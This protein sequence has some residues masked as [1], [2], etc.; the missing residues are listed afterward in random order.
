MGEVLID[1]LLG[2]LVVVWDYGEYSLNTLGVEV[3][4]A[5]P[6]LS[7]VVPPEADHD[8]AAPRHLLYYEAGDLI[9]LLACQA[10]RFARRPVD[11]D[12]IRRLILQ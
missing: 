1:A 11:D 9:T 6:D 10:G 4:N 5:L 8:G 12:K 3:R 2:R 7:G